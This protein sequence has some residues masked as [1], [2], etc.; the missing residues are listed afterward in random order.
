VHAETPPYV[1]RSTRGLSAGD[2]HVDKQEGTEL[3]QVRV[4]RSVVVGVGWEA[5]PSEELY[6]KPEVKWDQRLV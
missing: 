4:D 3:V 6:R 5:E 1:H 2:N